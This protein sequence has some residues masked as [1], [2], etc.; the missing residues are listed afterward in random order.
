V[1]LAAFLVALVLVV[2]ATTYAVVRGVS[3][4]RHAKSTGRT[5]SAELARFEE[6]AART[7]RL[8]AEADASST[9]LA[10][11]QERLRISRARLTVL[12]GAFEDDKRRTRWLRVFVPSR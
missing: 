11:A 5:F 12:L 7:E 3:L 6:R 10:A 4:W 1:I 2:A 8:L 9:A